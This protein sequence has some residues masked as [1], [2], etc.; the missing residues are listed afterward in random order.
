MKTASLTGKSL[1]SLLLLPILCLA[2]HPV[3]ADAPLK[4][5]SLQL[6]WYPQAE[7]G[8]YFYAEVNG[9]YRKA[10]LD[11][12]LI[13]ASVNTP[14]GIRLAMGQIEFAMSDENAQLMSRARGLPL[15]AVM[16]TMQHDPTAV[17]LHPDSPVKSFADLD[18]K[19][20]SV[21]PAM[22]WFQYVINKYH[23]T[24]VHQVPFTLQTSNFVEDPNYIQQC[25]VTSEPY[26]LGLHGI[27]VRTML[28]ADT[29]WDPYRVV[30]T[31]DSFLKAHPDEVQAFVSA[32]IEGWRRYQLDPAATDAEIRRRNPEMTQGLLD[33]SRL[34]LY[35]DHFVQGYPDKGE[36]IGL[37]TDARFKHQ[38]DLLRSLNIIPND[39]DYHQAFTTQFVT[40]PTAA[41]ASQP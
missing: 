16:A 39:Y 35:Q 6:D 1:R 41:A 20:V 32:S 10:G 4:H 18:G 11:V 8:G 27:K 5:V 21:I 17:M 36:A 9:L 14:L 24:H 15:I 34:H 38:Y 19:S 28:V 25:F 31:S 33:Y 23:L 37:I 29:G 22:S 12:D 3:E 30:L 40:P 13:P 2:A 26:V 7:Q